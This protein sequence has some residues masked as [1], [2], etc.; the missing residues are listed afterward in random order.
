MRRS[1][2]ILWCKLVIGVLTFP[3]LQMSYVEVIQRS[4][5]NG[6]FNAA[7]PFVD[8]QFEGCLTEVL[9]PCQWP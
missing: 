7:T 5:I 9:E 8:E 1:R 4:V 6:F 2:K 3:L